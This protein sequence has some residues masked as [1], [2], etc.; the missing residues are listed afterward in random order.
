MS[1]CVRR[2]F[3]PLLDSINVMVSDVDR[4]SPYYLLSRRL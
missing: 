1:F 4:L 3:E 2:R